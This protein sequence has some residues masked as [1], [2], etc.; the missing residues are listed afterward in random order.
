MTQTSAKITSVKIQDSP[1]PGYSAPPESLQPERPEAPHTEEDFV[2]EQVGG[3]KRYQDP[4]V[5][6][7]PTKLRSHIKATNR[8]AG[9]VKEASMRRAR[10]LNEEFMADSNGQVLDTLFADAEYS[11]PP[12][13]ALRERS[14]PP[15]PALR[16]RSVPP[17]PAVTVTFRPLYSFPF[18]C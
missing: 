11:T 13:P 17:Q 8:D 1:P 12:Q 18:C 9:L 2:E 14:V 10:L 16:E 7:T 3:G 5:E 15:Q 4:P 6:H